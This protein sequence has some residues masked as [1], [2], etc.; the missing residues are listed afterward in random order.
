MQGFMINMTMR[1]KVCVM[2]E[3]TSPKM[4]VVRICFRGLNLMAGRLHHKKCFIVRAAFELVKLVVYHIFPSVGWT[5]NLPSVLD[6]CFGQP[7]F[8]L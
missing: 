3:H 4:K 6:V 7:R 8:K 5:I 2:I 1:I